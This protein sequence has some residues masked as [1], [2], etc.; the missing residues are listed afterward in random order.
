MR[1]DLR[2]GPPGVSSQAS[3]RGRLDERS[4]LMDRESA[5]ARFVD[6]AA[7]AAK[8]RSIAAAG[9]IGFD[10]GIPDR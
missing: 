5:L 8:G 7:F 6:F 10:T 2:R 3:T 1:L 9:V 4:A